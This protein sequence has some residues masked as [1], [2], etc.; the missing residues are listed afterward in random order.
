VTSTHNHQPFSS[1]PLLRSMLA[2]EE[3]ATYHIHH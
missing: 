3:K 2:S 1:P